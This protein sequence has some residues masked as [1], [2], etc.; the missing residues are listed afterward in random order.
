MRSVLNTA[1]KV[2]LLGPAA[3]LVAALASGCAQPGQLGSP[4]PAPEPA[5]TTAAPAPTPEPPSG[6]VLVGSG[7]LDRPVSVRTPGPAVFSVRTVTLEPGESTGWH[8]HPG[9]ETSIVRSGTVTLQTE[10]DCDPV[11]FR[12]GQAAFVPDALSHLARNDGTEPAELVVTYLLAPGAADRM[13]V[14]PA[15]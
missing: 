7:L 1:R 6:P 10:D 8:A 11:E 5:P 13:T 14:P 2:A 9:T 12:S 4:A 15:C 3:A